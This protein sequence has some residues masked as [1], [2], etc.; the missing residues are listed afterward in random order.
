M[1]PSRGLVTGAGHGRLLMVKDQ[2]PRFPALGFPVMFCPCAGAV[3][4]IAVTLGRLRVRH[5]RAVVASH[6]AVAVGEVAR[7]KVA[8]AR[9]SPSME[10]GTLFGGETPACAS[11]QYKS[12][13][14]TFLSG[15]PMNYYSKGK[16][17][18]NRLWAM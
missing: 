17:C 3:Q 16:K 7:P 1:L 15:E 10:S 14:P 9:L 12:F 18:A 13:P 6:D 5:Q 4:A 11:S 8:S 2:L